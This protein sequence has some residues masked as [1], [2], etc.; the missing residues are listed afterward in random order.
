MVDQRTHLGASHSTSCVN[1]FF[2]THTIEQGP[3]ML[4]SEVGA[5]IPT[6]FQPGSDWPPTSSGFAVTSHPAQYAPYQPLRTTTDTFV[7][8]FPNGSQSI[9][10]GAGPAN[11]TSIHAA[12]HYGSSCP[13]PFDYGVSPRPPTATAS[14]SNLRLSAVPS[15][16]TSN[17]IFDFE[18]LEY[19]SCNSNL[20]VYR[21]CDEYKD[22]TS[23]D[24]GMD[25]GTNGIQVE[26]DV[27]Q[28][29]GLD[30]DFFSIGGVSTWR[31]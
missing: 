24:N 27:V 30:D 29:F 26:P 4:R 8:Y 16:I 20:D 9:E 18:D 31:Q 12:L 17:N 6:G 19:N 25:E 23:V 21:D 11:P 22:V 28:G 7:P 1:D 10:T 5:R 14:E 2:A 15:D 3:S 13:Q